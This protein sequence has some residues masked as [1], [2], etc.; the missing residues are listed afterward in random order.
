[1]PAYRVLIAAGQGQSGSNPGRP[2]DIGHW[3]KLG[4]ERHA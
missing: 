3:Q 2:L 4:S 1:M